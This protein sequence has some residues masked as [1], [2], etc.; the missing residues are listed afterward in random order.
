MTYQG[1]GAGVVDPRKLLHGGL[2]LDVLVSGGR[3]DAQDDAEASKSGHGSLG[4]EEESLR[5]VSRLRCA[6][7]VLSFY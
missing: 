1:T 6:R 4:A 5:R 2:I 3:W 7:P